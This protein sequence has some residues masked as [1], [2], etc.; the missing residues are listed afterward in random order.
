MNGSATTPRTAVL[1]VDLQVGV[2]PQCVDVEGVLARTNALT[3][4]ARTEGVPVVWVQDEQDF[5][6]DSDGW[7]LHPDLV[8]LP[9]EARVHKAYR[10]AF[11]GTD[12]QSVLARTGTTHLVLAGAQSDY[13]VRTLGQSAAAAG[14]DVTLVADCHTTTGAWLAGVWV[15]GEQIVAHVNAY[16]AGLRYPGQRF[17][18]VPHDRVAL[19]VASPV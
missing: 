1:V 2:L 16:F 9:G 18:A 13:C 14:Y 12:L 7:R 5:A 4:R 11:A 17:A 3:S 8:V 6:R 19:G 15:G 10:D